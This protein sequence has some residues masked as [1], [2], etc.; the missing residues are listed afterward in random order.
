MYYNYNTK[1]DLMSITNIEFKI[2]NN[3]IHIVNL[4]TEPYLLAITKDDINNFKYLFNL[5]L[6][7][8]EF[9]NSVINKSLID[10]IENYFIDLQ[11]IETIIYNIDNKMIEHYNIASY[12]IESIKN[13]FNIEIKEYI[14]KN[15][16]ILIYNEDE[17]ILFLNSLLITRNKVKN[18]NMNKL[19]EYRYNQLL[20]RIENIEQQITK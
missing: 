9:F 16:N 15:Y 2:V 13:K 6:I 4:N 19:Y 12:S 20:K 5:K 11:P 18:K 7:E 3:D 17:F 14:Y 1:N 10:K 8:I